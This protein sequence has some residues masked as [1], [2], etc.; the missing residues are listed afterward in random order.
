MGKRT[1]LPRHANM[2]IMRCRA[3]ITNNSAYE[4]RNEIRNEAKAK[5]KFVSP[6]SILGD[7]FKIDYKLEL[8]QIGRKYVM[9]LCI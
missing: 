6:Y 3:R 9:F 1:M 7:K 4:R 8:P 5:P 2:K